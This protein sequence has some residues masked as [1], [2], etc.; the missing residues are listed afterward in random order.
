MSE[1]AK[2]IEAPE[3]LAAGGAKPK[4][5]E[6]PSAWRAKW[7][8]RLKR[9]RK[10]RVGFLILFVA[11]LVASL[12]GLYFLYW[13]V[14]PPMWKW[15]FSPA[16]W[17][18]ILS[19]LGVLYLVIFSLM[20]PAFLFLSP[21]VDVISLYFEDEDE[22]LSRRLEEVKSHRRQA[23]EILAGQDV[24]GLLPLVQY[25]S[26]QLE[27][28]YEIGMAQ[29]RKSFRYSVVAMW[30]GFVVIIAGIIPNVVPLEKY[31][32]KASPLGLNLLAMAAGI[33]I[34]VISAMFLWIYRSSIAQQTYFYNR[35]IYTH[36]VLLSARIADSMGEGKEKAKQTIVRRI[37]DHR[38]QQPE[39]I[40]PPS[41]RGVARLPKVGPGRAGG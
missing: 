38:W 11:G 19:F 15:G 3:P 23:E 4:K 30:I 25:S 12:V 14:I 9:H 16:S 41:G 13:R 24:S 6:K 2:Q 7:L 31:G 36:G 40:A 17:K 22:S 8:P 27:A 18:A 20:I 32:L 37:L 21:M 26:A 39:R 10:M 33:V 34:E 5:E 35:Q 28:Y 1:P 29:T